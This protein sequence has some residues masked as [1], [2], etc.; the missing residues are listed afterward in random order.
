MRFSLCE[1]IIRAGGMVR[2]VWRFRSGSVSARSDLVE[3]LAAASFVLAP[4]FAGAEELVPEDFIV[5]TYVAG[6][7]ATKIAWTP[8][9]QSMYIGAKDGRVFIVQDDALVP[10]T[11]ID[12]RP[13]V[14]TRSDRGMLGLAIHPEFPTVN[15]VYLLYTYDPPETF[16]NFDAAG[17]NGHGQRVAQLLRVEADPNTKDQTAVA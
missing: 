5:E 1:I 2:A 7:D 15:Y 12:L 8:D 6:I 9:Q 16:D 11:F 17:N 13:E 4:V 10:G 3:I 14:N